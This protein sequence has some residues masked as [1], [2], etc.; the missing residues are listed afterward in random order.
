[1]LNTLTVLISGQLKKHFSENKFTAF[2]INVCDKLIY[3][4]KVSLL[5]HAVP[6][7]TANF[8]RKEILGM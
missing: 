3:V 4:S 8:S 2:S 7:P 6:I 1:M 5:R